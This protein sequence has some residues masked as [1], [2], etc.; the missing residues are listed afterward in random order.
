M[1]IRAGKYLDEN[2]QPIPEFFEMVDELEKRLVYA[3]ENTSLPVKPDF[4]RI[5]E[6]T[7]DV[8]RDVVTGRAEYWR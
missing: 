8:N 7:A 2:S 3:R 5:Q 6:F 4:R 1:D